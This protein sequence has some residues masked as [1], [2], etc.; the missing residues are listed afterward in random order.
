[1]CTRIF[2]KF[3]SSIL[4]G[5]LLKCVYKSSQKDLCLIFPK[6]FYSDMCL[7]EFKFTI[8]TFIPGHFSKV[9]IVRYNPCVQGLLASA[10]YDRTVKIW[11]LNTATEL[12]TLQEHPESVSYLCKIYIFILNLFVV[13]I[14]FVSFLVCGLKEFYDIFLGN[15]WSCSLLASHFYWNFFTYVQH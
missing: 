13:S 8:F 12:I 9:N 14:R 2:A 1:M 4:M 11:D 5:T 7:F 10:S 3:S 6:T 15:C